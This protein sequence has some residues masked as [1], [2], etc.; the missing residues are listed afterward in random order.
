M[1]AGRLQLAGADVAGRV[2]GLLSADARL[3][4]LCTPPDLHP[5]GPVY[6]LLH[7]PKTAGQTIQGHLAEH[8]APG[9]LSG[10]LAASCARGITPGP[11]T[12]PI[13]PVRV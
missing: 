5:D 12:S 4:S 7:V 6:F 1:A 10:D 9:G 11:A 13:S 3:R 8:C 2:P